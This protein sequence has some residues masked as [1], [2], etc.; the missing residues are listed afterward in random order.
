MPKP[1]FLRISS[2]KGGVGKTTI[3]VNLSTA[4]VRQGFKVPWMAEVSMVNEGTISWF[5][6]AFI[7]CSAFFIVI[8][9]ADVR[10][11]FICCSPVPV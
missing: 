5:G 10:A 9:D 6:V 1:Y 11:K 2:Q 4:L 3:A 7:D 8:P